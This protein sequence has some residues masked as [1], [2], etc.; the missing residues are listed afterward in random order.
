MAGDTSNEDLIC[1]QYL[2]DYFHVPTTDWWNEAKVAFQTPK[3]L[4]KFEP[5][6]SGSRSD[7][8]SQEGDIPS[9]CLARLGALP[10]LICVATGSH[11]LGG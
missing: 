3:N 4:L 5:T 7:P 11:A 9:A 1:V 10:K 6:F 2:Q 8:E